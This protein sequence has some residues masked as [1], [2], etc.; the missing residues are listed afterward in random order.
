MDAKRTGERTAKSSVFNDGSASRVYA[1]IVLSIQ[2]RM[3]REL[4]WLLDVEDVV[5]DAWLTAIEKQKEFRG[6]TE[7]EL[8]R[9][10]AGI[11]RNRIRAARR[12]HEFR[13][14]LR[15]SG[16]TIF[17]L[18]SIPAKEEPIEDRE[19]RREMEDQVHEAI[20]T[21]L[22][23]FEAMLVKKAF[24][25]ERTT[26]EIAGGCR[27]SVRHVRRLL[28]QALMKLY[29]HFESFERVRASR[30]QERPRPTEVAEARRKNR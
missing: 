8:L 17:D 18:E 27:L 9:W 24:L 20:R 7:A 30:R 5:Q 26:R 22:G 13:K 21:C 25:E 12:C 4:S 16:D 15:A 29:Q 3:P 11:G 14:R 19:A 2:P 10:M 28:A 23:Q 6:T 1:R